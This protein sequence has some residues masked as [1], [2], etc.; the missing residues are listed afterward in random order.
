MYDLIITLVEHP[1]WQDRLLAPKKCSLCGTT[2]VTISAKLGVCRDCLLIRA[3]EALSIVSDIRKKYRKKYSLPL[4]PPRT[5]GGLLCGDCVNNCVL[6]EGERGFCNLVENKDQKLVRLAG[7]ETG[8]LFGFYYDRLPTN[9]VAAPYCAGCSERGYPKY[10]IK[11]GAEIGRNNLAV[12]YQGCTFDCLFCQN[13]NFRKEIHSSKPQKPEVL[14][15]AIKKDTTCICFFG[16][17]PAAQI[18]HSNAVGRLALE[19]AQDEHQILRVCWETNG[20]A[21]SNYLKESAKIALE[22]G[23]C[24]KIDVKT[25]DEPLNKALCGSSNRFTLK[26]VQLIGELAKARPELPLLVVSTLLIPGYVDVNQVRSIAKFIASIDPSI[27]YSLLAFYPTFVMNDLPT[28]SKEQAEHCFQAAK[29]EGLE[30][31]SIGNKHLLS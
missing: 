31:V 29:E 6:G 25:F 24:I 5:K 13:Y 16:G 8:G 11:N 1:M 9:C 26:N 3:E 12:F 4:E 21:H 7:D 17:D 23:G 30:R 2:S 10:S 28:T 19:K 14:V 27:P 20:S 22:S 18:Q 15:N